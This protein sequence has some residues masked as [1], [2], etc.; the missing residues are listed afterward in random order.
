MTQT[1]PSWLRSFGR[2]L[3]TLSCLALAAASWVSY[4]FWQWRTQT[5]ELSEERL[6][7]YPKGA[8]LLE[9]SAELERLGVISRQYYFHALI[10][11]FHDSKQL[12]AGSY[13]FAGTIS[14]QQ[15]ALRVMAGENYRPEV[16]RFTIPE[17]FT[18]KQVI[19][20]LHNQ[21]L[22][23]KPDLIDR[24]PF[25]RAFIESLDLE[26]PE[27]SKNLP[28]GIRPS[29]EGYLFPATYTFYDRI[30]TAK[31]VYTKMVQTFHQ[32]LAKDFSQRLAALPMTLHRAV[33][34]ASLIEKET[35]IDEERALVSEVIWRRLKNGIPLA[36]DAG[37]IYGIKD[38]AG[39]I[40]WRHLRDASNPYNSRIHKGLPPTPI[41]QP[42]KKSLLA[43]VEPSNDGYY[44]YVVKPNSNGRHHFSRSL[45]EHQRHVDN[46][47]K[48]ERMPS[49]SANQP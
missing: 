26:L 3:L 7:T 28:R 13:R 19:A 10:R 12:K 11:L 49:K 37:L 2:I 1:P 21:P 41:G 27:I 43:V 22:K 33:T 47:V 42:G 5:I 20:R 30:P 34:M 29:L 48:A 15:V 17:G 45:K 44:Y 32:Q 23:G 25:D 46:W 36:I 18:L 39:D 24:L 40:K 35:R 8:S 4:D 38:Y 31:E 9:L 16:L 6:L 14:P